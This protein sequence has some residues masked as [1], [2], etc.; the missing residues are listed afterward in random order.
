ML[1]R[2]SFRQLLLAPFVLVALLLGGVALRG[3]LALEALLEKGRDDA[4]RTLS[5]S[6]HAERLDELALAME[7]AARQYLVLGD[8]TLRQRYQRSADDA[9]AH[10]RPLAR[11][12]IA[13]EAAA[14]WRTQRRAV[15]RLLTDG[16]DPARDAAL[17]QAFR[18]IAE[19][20]ARLMQQ[21]RAETAARNAMLQDEIEATRVALPLLLAWPIAVASAS[22]A[23]GRWLRRHALLLTPEEAAPPPVLRRAW[24]LANAASLPMSVPMP[25][26]GAVVARQG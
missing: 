26:A 4:A 2:P 19:Q 12:G 22:P 25:L 1:P 5:L 21:L 18:E 16:A 15:D 17:V 7:R 20:Q 23:L 24:A 6:A 9:E 11:D 8:V 13:P 14:A 3:Q 10:L